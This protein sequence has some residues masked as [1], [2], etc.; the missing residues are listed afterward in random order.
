MSNGLLMAQLGGTLVV[1]GQLGRFGGRSVSCVAQETCP[2]ILRC[3]C[4]N[5]ASL[6]LGP[7]PVTLQYLVTPN[8]TNVRGGSWPMH[9]K[10]CLAKGHLRLGNQD[11]CRLERG[12]QKWTLNLI[13]IHKQVYLPFLPPFTAAEPSRLSSI[14]SLRQDRVGCEVIG[15]LVASAKLENGSRVFKVCQND[16][17]N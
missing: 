17:N 5:A 12:S 16:T 7:S 11:I 1:V 6:I 9:L 14:P 4:A 15:R 13:P 8:M 3:Q 2:V 10:A